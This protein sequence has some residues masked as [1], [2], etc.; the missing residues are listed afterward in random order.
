MI[1]MTELIDEYLE[2]KGLSENTAK[3]QKSIL[4]TFNK[5][6][7]G[8]KGNDLMWAA[9]DYKEFLGQ[10]DGIKP[11]TFK[12]HSNLVKAFCQ[13]ETSRREKQPLELLE[14]TPQR[15]A[16]AT[17]LER[18]C[19]AAIKQGDLGKRNASMALLAITCGLTMEEIACL[20][21]ADLRFPLLSNGTI[22]RGRQTI[23]MPDVT[24]DMLWLYKG[25]EECRL[26]AYVFPKPGDDRKPMR[27]TD[28]RRCVE[29]ILDRAGVDSC[30]L[31]QDGAEATIRAHLD[32]LD[33]EATRA[34]CTFVKTL[35]YSK[36]KFPDALLKKE[37][38][39]M[40][41]ARKS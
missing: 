14:E 21:V 10:R 20:L 19:R 30:V 38:R 1:D 35:S 13:W 16:T 32:T 25:T 15:P 28:V 22:C 40:E 36:I 7:I 8:F 4:M 9:A 24:T 6:A 37:I 5:W 17:E 26:F 33:A 41:Q 27:P 12:T 29:D 2:S 23:T 11:K 3:T 18:I 39:A 34:V 31:A